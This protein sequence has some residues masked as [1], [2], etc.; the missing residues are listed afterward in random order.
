MKNK[1]R[2]FTKEHRQKISDS[3]KRIAEDY[4]YGGRVS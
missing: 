4:G 1:L 3:R 2:H